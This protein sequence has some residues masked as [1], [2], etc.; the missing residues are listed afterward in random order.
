MGLDEVRRDWTRLGAADPLWAVLTHAGKRGGRW[1]DEEFLASGRAEIDAA[2]ARLDRLGVVSGRER[3]LDFGCGAGRLSNA[4]A[5]RFGEVV[6]VDVSAPMLE[7]ARR[8]DGSGGRIRFVHNVAPDLA[9]LPDDHVDLVYTDLVLQ[10][11][12]PALARGYLREFVR[13][14]R[15]EG[16]LLA[17]M[18]DRHERTLP[19]LMSR[20]APLAVQR[21]FQRVVLR[22]PAPMRMHTMP[23]PELA[24]LMN[25]AGADV[26]A[27]DALGDNPHWRHIRY[28]VVKRP[29]AVP[30]AAPTLSAALPA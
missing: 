28:V 4:L 22:H 23:Q 18:P 10:H 13:V 15:P 3:A 14:L 27:A 19:G 20:Y 8:L 12:P 30:A 29:A 1:A 11:L 9:V 24:A 21:V 26:I 7:Q 2:M 5:Q 16:V 6:G 25:D 17:G